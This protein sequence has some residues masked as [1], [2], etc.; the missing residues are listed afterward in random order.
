MLPSRTSPYF[1]NTSLNV[2]SVVEKD[3]PVLTLSKF[4]ADHKV[5]ETSFS[6]ATA[7]GLKKRI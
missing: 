7:Y 1:E 4:S 6:N 5:S 3:I 2:D